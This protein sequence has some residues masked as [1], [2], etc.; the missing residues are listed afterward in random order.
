MR[1]LSSVTFEDFEACLGQS[2]EVKADTGEIIEF[3]LIEVK[4]RGTFDP[5]LDARQ[6]F[7]LLFRGPSEPALGQAQY[8]ITNAAFGGTSLFLVPCGPDKQGLLYDA[9]IA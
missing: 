5:E 1:D 4:K 9:T 6:A 8:E 7:S 3:D 2:F